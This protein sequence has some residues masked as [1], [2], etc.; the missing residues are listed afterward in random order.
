MVERSAVNRLVGGS[1]PSPGAITRPRRPGVGGASPRPGPL[2]RPG[3]RATAAALALLA[4]PAT[5]LPLAGCASY[6]PKPLT[7]EAVEAALAPPDLADLDAVRLRARLADPGALPPVPFDP[8]DGLSSDE[9]A[10]LAVLANPDLRAARAR[11]GVA[12]AQLLAAGIL[13]NPELSAAFEEPVGGSAE[14]TVAGWALGLDWDLA[15]V[16]SRGAKVDAARAHGREVELDVAWKEW[17][18]A[19]GAR[20]HLVRLAI[21]E[22]RLAE[23]G[24]A[25]TL[26]ADALGATRRAVALG[27]RT[28]ADLADARDALGQARAALL[29][30]RSERDA[31]R[32]ELDRALGLPA[33]RRVPIEGGAREP[34]AGLLAARPPADGELAAGLA[35]RRLDLVA[36]RAGYESQ[37][38]RLRAAVRSR[39]PA[40]RIGLEAARDPEDIETAGAGVTIGLPLFDRGQGRIAVER[41]TREQLFDEYAARL[42]EARSELARIDAQLAPLRREIAAATA[43]LGPLERRAQAERRAAERGTGDR[44]AY[45]RAAAALSAKRLERLALERRLADLT[46]ALEIA[47]GRELLGSGGGAGGP[48]AAESA[49]TT[50]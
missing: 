41:A 1:N 31:E 44:F 30:A 11:R 45:A 19:E 47:S 2:P 20:L 33:G 15:A 24:R 26:R 38:A 50:P 18:V 43:A 34:I 13:P 49:E 28:A 48:T 10:I 22:R 8:S 39:F 21:A 12:R 16:L 5:L 25:R 3:R 29:E 23:A 35:D 27:V 17:Q 14:H 42:A 37:E 36:L 9:A 32:V 40:I 7:P 46:V 6:S 4:L